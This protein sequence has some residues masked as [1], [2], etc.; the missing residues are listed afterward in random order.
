MNNGFSLFTGIVD[1]TNDPDKQGKI[2]VRILTMH[3]AEGKTSVQAGDLSWAI[4]IV[5]VTADSTF[6]IGVAPVGITKG[7]YVMGFFADANEKTYPFVMGSWAVTGVKEDGSDHG[8][9]V[10][11]RGEDPVAKTY[12][13]GVEPV[14]QYAAE[15]P[16][17]RVMTTK[18]GHVIEVDDTKG[19]ER[20]H[21]YHAKGTYVEMNPDGSAVYKTN[22][23]S[24]YISGKDALIHAEGDINITAKGMIR[25]AA[26]KGI[27]LNSPGG[28]TVKSGNFYVTDGHAGVRKGAS[29]VFTTST[30]QRVYVED[31]IIIKVKKV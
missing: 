29:D 13:A 4:P 17:N 19:A 27:K 12:I 22:E 9:S 24:Y 30:G 7:S 2:K 8:V 11:A 16:S 20:I 26:G 25:L 10:Y 1:D 15:Y 23:D 18:N 28:T 21:I 3:G 31:G 5:P 14:S 6:G